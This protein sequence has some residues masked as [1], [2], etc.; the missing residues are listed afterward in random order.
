MPNSPE[1]DKAIRDGYIHGFIKGRIPMAEHTTL[2]GIDEVLGFYVRNQEKLEQIA[3][4]CCYLLL[5]KEPWNSPE[6]A[7]EFIEGFAQKFNLSKELKNDLHADVGLGTWVPK[8]NL[9]LFKSLPYWLALETTVYR[10]FA[11]TLRELIP[12]ETGKTPVT[13]SKPNSFYEEPPWA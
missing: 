10:R 13:I 9:G 4:D 3:K 5:S 7:P 2:T 11:Q 8:H 12:E 1:L 6:Y